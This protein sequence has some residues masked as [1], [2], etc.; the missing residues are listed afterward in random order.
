MPGSIKTLTCSAH[1]GTNIKD[2]W[3]W[4]NVNGQKADDLEG[5]SQN[6]TRSTN[7]H[8]HT[9]IHYI[10]LVRI[11]CLLMTSLMCLFYIYSEYV[12]TKKLYI[13]KSVLTIDR[14]SVKDFHST[15]KCNA[16]TDQS[17]TVA[18][19]FLKPEGLQIDRKS[20]V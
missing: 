11:S 5:Y 8:T 18:A 10:V 9:Y 2:C 16:M 6:L 17:I 1:C 13:F 19:L 4:W 15:F 7:A 12:T 3:V 14:V 20:V